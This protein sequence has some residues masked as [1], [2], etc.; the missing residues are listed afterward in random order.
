MSSLTDRLLFQLSRLLRELKEA[1]DAQSPEAKLLC[2]LERKL[3]NMELRHQSRE[4]ELQQ[5]HRAPETLAV[6]CC[7]HRRTC[8]PLSWQ[9]IGRSWQRSEADERS[10]VECWRR[11]AEDK[12]RQLESFRQ[13]LDSILDMV[14]CLQR[15]GVVVPVP[16]LSPGP[17]LT[18]GLLK[19]LR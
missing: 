1:R 19:E 18:A 14:R 4:Q 3:L 8:A 13:E 6:P 10:Q 11:V 7:S 12:S 17:H 15:E 5:V 9:V 2:S 16:A